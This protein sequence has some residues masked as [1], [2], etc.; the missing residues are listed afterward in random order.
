MVRRG[1][2]HGRLRRI[3]NALVMEEIVATELNSTVVGCLQR[4]VAN[5]F[6]LHVNYKRYHWYVSGPLF[7]ELHL[8]FDDHAQ[9]ILETLDELGERVRILGGQPVATLSAIRETMT[10]L[11]PALAE[12]SVRTMLDEAIGN[13]R[14][15]ISEL[16]EGVDVATRNNDPGTADLFTRTVQIHEKQEWFLRETA[17]READSR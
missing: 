9:Q 7:R 4:Q 11:E 5:A 16:R 13:H 6:A 1:V 17:N 10:V 15:I 2:P 12:H 3:V 8:L 14:R